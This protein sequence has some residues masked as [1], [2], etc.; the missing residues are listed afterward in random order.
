MERANTWYSRKVQYILLVLGFVIAFAVN[1]DTLRMIDK[2]NSD[3]KLRKEL[4]ESA[5]EYVKNNPEI[6]AHPKDSLNI[7]VKIEK[8]YNTLLSESHNLLGWE[9]VK[10]GQVKENEKMNIKDTFSEYWD[11][12]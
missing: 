3:E 7:Q 1:G 2:L 6:K 4:V 8:E 10:P 5:T 12:Y 9:K 11:F